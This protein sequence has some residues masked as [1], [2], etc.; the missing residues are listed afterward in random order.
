MKTFTRSLIAGAL[1]MLMIP[2][3][4]MAY[5]GCGYGY[6]PGYVQRDINRDRAQLHY[7]REDIARDRYQLH[8]DLAYGN[9]RVARAERADI[10][11]DYNQMQG[12]RMDLGRDYQRFGY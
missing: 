5:D 11:R 3:A 7:D 2:A 4:A 12:R 6:R 10:N 8:Q 9:W 1:M